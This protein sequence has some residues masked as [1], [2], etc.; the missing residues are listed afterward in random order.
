MSLELI[1]GATDET[2]RGIL[3]NMLHTGTDQA[4]EDIVVMTFQTRD[5]RGG[6]GER[7]LFYKMMTYLYQIEPFLCLTLLDLV[8]EYGSWDDMFTLANRLPIKASILD[9]AMKQLIKDESEVVLGGAISLLGK[10]APREGRP[11]ATEFAH[12]LCPTGKH[13]QIMS[14]YRKRLS[15]LNAVLKTVETLECSNRWD[16]IDPTQVPRAALRRKKLAYLNT[17]KSGTLRRPDDEKRM[18]CREH[19]QGF[20]APTIQP[21][22]E[23]G[24]YDR[25][26]ERVREWLRG[27][28]RI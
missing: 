25:V 1:R 13:S 5:V 27:G 3:S 8:P 2:I 26:R 12:L 21:Q 19:F 14:S 28:W 6:E 24:R 17:N 11:L 18:A 9:I 10:W 4:Y 15:R 23:E 20:E 22:C 7:E 16:T